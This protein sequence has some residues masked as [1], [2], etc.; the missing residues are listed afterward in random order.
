MPSLNPSS[1]LFGYHILARFLKLSLIF[2]Y[3]GMMSKLISEIYCERRHAKHSAWQLWHWLSFSCFLQ[4]SSWINTFKNI[5][6]QKPLWLLTTYRVKAKY[7]GLGDRSDA[8]HH[9]VPFPAVLSNPF[10][11][12]AAWNFSVFFKEAFL[13]LVSTSFHKWFP[14]LVVLFSIISAWYPPLHSQCHFLYLPWVGPTLIVLNHK[15]ILYI[16]IGSSIWM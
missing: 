3:K 9:F 1:P 10:M 16:Y 15:I 4:S 13:S 11:L 7:L 12:Q 5:S 14:L 6:K 2:R 8:R